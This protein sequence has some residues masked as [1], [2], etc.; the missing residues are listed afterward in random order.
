MAIEDNMIKRFNCKFCNLTF[1]TGQALGGHQNYHRTER[2][3]LWFASQ[4]CTADPLNPDHRPIIPSHFSHDPM[5]DVH[6]SQAFCSGHVVGSSSVGGDSN[7]DNAMWLRLSEV[8]QAT[9]PYEVNFQALLRGTK[10]YK[11]EC[12]NKDGDELDLTLHL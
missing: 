3:A 8:N 12:K 11:E 2:N 10:Y 5:C 1:T 9:R 6:V 7:N 4:P